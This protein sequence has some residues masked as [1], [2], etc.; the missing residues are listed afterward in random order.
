[1]LDLP[2]RDHAR[3][4]QRG[5][6][7]VVTRVHQLDGIADRRERIAQFVRERREKLVLATIS[8]AQ[9]FLRAM[10]PQQRAHV[11]DEFSRLDRLGQIAVRAAIE[12]A[13]LVERLHSGRR[14]LQ[15]ECGARLRI[16]LEDRTHF[17]AADV[18]QLH[19]EQH[20]RG[21][22]RAHLIERALARGRLDHLETGVHEHARFRIARAVVVVDV[23]NEGRGKR[24]DA[25]PCAV[26]APPVMSPV[27]PPVAPS[28]SA[29]KGNVA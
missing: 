9:R 4:A 11:G 19:V 16:A 5:V 23:E 25:P 3:V 1:M 7:G 26:A 27:A 28:A 18:G 8:V 17:D 20:E 15:D 6:V 24:H 10:Q 14:R 29:F 13:D 12:R 22:V 2:A 21:L